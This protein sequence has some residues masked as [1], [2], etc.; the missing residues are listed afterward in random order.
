MPLS[1]IFQLYRGSQFICGGKRSTQRK[2]AVD[3]ADDLESGNF[4]KTANNVIDRV[5]PKGLR[6]IGKTHCLLKNRTR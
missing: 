6:K 3:L 4:E 5:V 2:T 1:T